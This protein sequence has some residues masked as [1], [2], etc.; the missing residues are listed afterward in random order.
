MNCIPF[1]INFI[2][3]YDIYLNF[4]L[5]VSPGALNYYLVG[6]RSSSTLWE[7]VQSSFLFRPEPAFVQRSLS[8]LHWHKGPEA[9]MYNEPTATI[10]D[11]KDADFICFQ[12]VVSFAKL[13]AKILD[14]FYQDFGNP[15]NASK[16][17][18]FTSAGRFISISKIWSCENSKH[19]NYSK[20]L[21][22][23]LKV[24]RYQANEQKLPEE[25]SRQL[26]ACAMNF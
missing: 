21:D 17:K 20:N 14:I 22:I 2:Q 15:W 8:A 25:I 23:H 1:F 3:V 19:F 10:I 9:S 4:T 16:I 24:P 11:R 6:L 5:G 18:T 12:L 13:T 26:F 7:A